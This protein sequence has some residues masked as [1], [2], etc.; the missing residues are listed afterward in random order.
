MICVF[1]SPIHANGG[2]IFDDPTTFIEVRGGGRGRRTPP[3]ISKIISFESE[4]KSFQLH[5]EPIKVSLTSLGIDLEIK[6]FQRA[7]AI[8][9]AQ[10]DTI[11]FEIDLFRE[12][13]D[14]VRVL[15]LIEDTRLA[16]LFIADLLL[17]LI[18][19]RNIRRRRLDEE[20]LIII[21]MMDC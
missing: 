20:E 8:L 12:K 3:S 2:C 4:S 15:L 1:D 16:N 21:L 10:I 7:I 14:E 6:R 9:Q 17:Q 13:E 18:E 11:Q 19:L 5:I